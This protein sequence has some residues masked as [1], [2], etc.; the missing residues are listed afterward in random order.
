[1]N[2]KPRFY[3]LLVLLSLSLIL[4]F[5]VLRPF[6]YSLIL[7]IVFSIIF[8]P[9]YQKILKGLGGKAWLASLLTII[10][11][12]IF[13]LVPITFLIIQVFQEAQSLYLSLAGGLGNQT[14][15]DL[16]PSLSQ[17]L[18]HI[19]PLFNNLSLDFDQYL[20]NIL[21]F[22]VQNLGV[23]FSNLARIFASLF[24]FLFAFFFLLKDGGQLKQKITQISP[25][26]KEDDEAIVKKITRAINAVIKGSLFVAVLQGISSSIGF[27]IFGVPNPII[28]G[29]IAAIGALIPGVGTTI[30][31]APAIIYLY[32]TGQVIGAIGLLAWGVLAVGLIDNFLGPR[33]VGKGAGLHPLLILLSVLGG[34]SLFGPVGFILGPL[35]ISLLIVLLDI[36]A[37]TAK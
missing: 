19:S 2:D 26:S 37:T 36:Y 11:L 7:A 20:K 6:L 1:M 22:L 21:S 23:L 25:L 8:Q 10:V 3:F 27:L 34:L 17:K 4:A 12:I 15:S 29:T 14:L 18:S 31:L 30:V 13:I 32:L 35:V 24:V 5:F 33:F 16:W 28:W 9:L